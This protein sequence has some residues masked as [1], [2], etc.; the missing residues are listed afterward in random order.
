[1]TCCDQ[2]ADAEIAALQGARAQQRL[3][4]AELGAHSF[5]NLVSLP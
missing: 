2:H 4:D 5:S 3:L 1:M